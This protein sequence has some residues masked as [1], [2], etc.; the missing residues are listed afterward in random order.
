MPTCG[1]CKQEGQTVEHIKQCYADRHSSTITMEVPALVRAYVEQRDFRPMA[2]TVPDSKYALIRPS[3]GVLE[4]FEVRTGHGKWDGMQFVDR[5]IG[6]PGDWR[7]TPV[8]G[9]EKKRVMQQIDSDPKA[10]AVRYSR[11]FTVCAVCGSPLS[12][13]ES[14]AQGLG[15]ICARRF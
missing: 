1:N 10:S 14:L 5:L 7:K 6:A 13:P 11:E 4:F 15:P 8:K 12:D 2:L 3:D 9:A